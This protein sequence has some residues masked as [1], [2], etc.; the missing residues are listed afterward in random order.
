MEFAEQLLERS[1]SPAAIFHRYRVDPTIEDRPHIFV[2]GYD[3]LL[4]YGNLVGRLLGEISKFHICFGKRNLDRI[5]VLFQETELRPD[6]TLFI[7]DSDFDYFLGNVAPADH[8]FLTA[9]YAVENYVCSAASV[10]S[11]I[12][13]LFGL[14]EDEFDAMAEV[15]KFS[16]FLSRIFSWLTPIH[17]A[18][19]YASRQ[20]RILDL[21][22]LDFDRYFT[23][24]VDGDVLPNPAEI[25]ELANMHLV[26]EDFSEES[27]ALG[28]AYGQ[29]DYFLWLRGKY[30]IKA[31]SIFLRKLES[32]VRERH[33]AGEIRQFNRR[34]H[35]D[36]SPNILFE[37][38]IAH[39]VVDADLRDVLLKLA[40]NIA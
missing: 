10:R 31:L 3:D 27:L 24:V 25:A 11:L 5:F 26:E 14:H 33:K 21:D 22:Q 4:F 29:Q 15:E 2:E 39:V 36:F 37:R 7:R 6:R 13:T 28:E 19:L 12:L 30:L 17:G 18:I 35:P 1:R 8:L 34:V 23:L 40:P 9:G 38:I 20:L 32:D 16:G